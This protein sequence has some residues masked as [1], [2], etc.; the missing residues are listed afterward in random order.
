[1][2]IALIGCGGIGSSLLP[3]L[4]RSLYSKKISSTTALF[5]Q[6]VLIDGDHYERKN[7]SRQQFPLSFIGVNKAEAQREKLKATLDIG[8]FITAI[9]SYVTEENVYALLDGV[10]IVLSGVDNTR[11]RWVIG[12]W[13]RKQDA[14]LKHFAVISGG[15]DKVDGN[16]HIHAR[17]GIS[18][19][20]NAPVEDLCIGEPIDSR[21][22]EVAPNETEGS[23]EHMS[24]QEVIN[25]RGGEQTMMANSMAAILMFSALYALRTNPIALADVQDTYFDCLNYRF[26]VVRVGEQGG[27]KE[28]SFDSV[29]D[30]GAEETEAPPLA[31]ATEEFPDITITA[32]N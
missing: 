18:K 8:G 28:L 16:V 12:Q 5:D 3:L 23:R 22:P 4:A 10:D 17:L 7:I 2:K 19:T 32:E 26:N 31:P 30:G 15:N 1:M 25:L 21:H 13:A 20:P 29:E 24:C 6:L 14:E 11:A 9:P 27:A